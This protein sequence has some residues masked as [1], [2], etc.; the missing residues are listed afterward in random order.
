MQTARTV[1]ETL[2]MVSVK[3]G[4]GVTESGGFLRPPVPQ[5]LDAGEFRTDPGEHAPVEQLGHLAG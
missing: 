4:A 2:S 5:Q 1:A 3:L